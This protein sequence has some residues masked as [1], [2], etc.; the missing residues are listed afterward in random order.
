[1]NFFAVSDLV[2]VF[3]AVFLGVEVHSKNPS[4]KLNKIF[5]VNA[6]IVSYTALCEYFRLSAISE[7]VALFWYKASFVWPFLPFML[8]GIILQIAGSKLFFNKYLRLSI[9]IPAIFITI[10]HLFTDAL[11][12][13]MSY[14]WYGWQGEINDNLISKLVVV[15]LMCISFFSIYFLMRFYKE[16]KDEKKKRQALFA[17]IGLT[18][19]ILGGLITESILRQFKFNIPPVNSIMYVIGTTFLAI[20]ILKYDFFLIDPIDVAKRLFDTISDYLLIY[21]KEGIIILSSISLNNVLKYDA[22]KIIG[23]N[24]FNLFEKHSLVNKDIFKTSGKE[25][26]ATLNSSDGHS[27]PISI[28][29]SHVYRGY[30][31][32]ELFLLLG[33]DLRERKQFENELLEMHKNLELKVLERTNDLQITNQLLSEEIKTRTQV[34]A[35]ISK[36][37]KEKEI[38]LKEIHHR[39]KNNMQI[40]SSLLYLQQSNSS[41]KF[42]QQILQESQH[43]VQTMSL[44]HEYLYNHDDLTNIDF[45][46]YVIKLLNYIGNSYK[47][48]HLNIKTEFDLDTVILPVEMIMPLG[49][50]LNELYTNSIKYAFNNNKEKWLDNFI[51]ITLKNIGE[52]NYILRI[53]DN[54]QG[55]QKD[56]SIN[57]TN[58]LGMKL[59][60]NLV[61]QFGGKFSFSS[62]G[63]TEFSIYFSLKKD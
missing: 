35:K 41:D 50:I 11:Y 44:V 18:L 12:S 31:Q 52:S 39:V 43:R 8:L 57:K 16:K 5:F 28:V 9:L 25:F 36:A 48:S 17:L 26:E 13:K 21:D 55:L 30:I 3:I 22:E 58:S 7:S 4:N 1:M 54:G 47:T 53:T 56:F 37:L 63:L 62:D 42:V 46:S 15:Y 33:R 61:N 20:S 60:D 23:Q 2:N 24:I 10:I 34:E 27:I 40:I 29:I 59:V 49:L 32:N 19:P 14:N 45:S 51:R 38:L 6:M